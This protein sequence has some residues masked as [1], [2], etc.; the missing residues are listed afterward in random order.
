MLNHSSSGSGNGRTR[1]TLGGW[2]GVALAAALVVTA[3]VEAAAGGAY[4][5]LDVRGAG[6]A[7]IDAIRRD[8]RVTWWVELDDVVLVG[9]DETAL[10]GL[11]RE[12]GGRL[13]AARAGATLRVV[14]GVP[15]P[16]LAARGARVL[17]SGGRWVVVEL[18]AS[19]ED[20]ALAPGA[21]GERVVVR[22]FAPNVVLARAL[23]N[24]PPRVAAPVRLAAAAP[25]DDVEVTRWF[26]DVTTLASWNRYTYGAGIASAR[27]WL[28]QRFE[29]L[30]G[31]AVST[32]AFQVNGTTAHNVIARFTGAT[33]PDDWLIVGGHYDSTS[34][35]PATSAPGAEDNA[36]GC[37]GVLEMARVFAAHPPGPTL[38]FVCYAGEEQGLYG[39]EAH[40]AWLV[41][42]GNAAKVRAVFDM[43]MIGYSGDADLDCLLE[44][45]AAFASLLDVYAAAAEA[46][47]P[48]RIVTSLDPYGS[49]HV[50]YLERG[51]GA[52]LAIENDWDTYADYHRTTDTPDKLAP[53]LIVGEQILRMNVAALATLA[54]TQCTDGDGDGYG[55]PASVACAEPGPDCDDADAAVNPGVH[56]VAGNGLDDD[57]D[58][59][60]D[61]GSACDGA[62]GGRQADEAGAALSTEVILMLVTLRCMRTWKKSMTTRHRP[63]G[64]P[65]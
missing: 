45:G 55:V 53:S 23:A 59:L 48:L 40:A 43:D 4:A 61:E 64:E 31:A 2:R 41:T 10:A 50:P 21:P 14:G 15:A 27:T 65:T 39:S 47:T 1:G 49:D 63:R 11:A 34:Q 42:S 57:C 52:V 37:A 7:V 19:G 29:A 16:L 8:P 46:Y 12:H 60:I 25:V 44:T 30:P 6:F 13:L 32:Q 20:R 58:S 3:A 35:A 38:L 9:G 17:A 18:A 33:A 28:V 62:I 24:A 56:E 51:M 5:R 36:S 22:P 26:A 54:T